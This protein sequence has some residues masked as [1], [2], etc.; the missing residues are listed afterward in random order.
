M[1]FRPG[2]NLSSQ[3]AATPLY[4]KNSFVI[5]ILLAPAC[6]FY[7]ISAGINLANFAI[8]LGT[9]H[10]S[11]SEITQILAFD[12][13]GNVMMAPL[14]PFLIRYFGIKKFIILSIILR[15]VFLF[16]FG[17][18]WSYSGW[19]L[20]MFGFG[21]FGFSLYTTIFQ[22]INMIASNE[23]RGTY[24]SVASVLFG[25]GMS[26][27]PIINS[28]FNLESSY[29]FAISALIATL[30][31]IPVYFLP[32]SIDYPYS[33]H[34]INITKLLKFS[35]IS[36]MCA[37][38]GEFTFYSMHEFL[39][40]YTIESDKG[41]SEAFMLISYFSLSGLMLGIP[42]GMIIDR[43]ERIKIIM[44]LV[45]GISAL[46]QLLPFAMHDTFFAFLIFS[47]LSACMNGVIICGLVIIGDKFRGHEFVAAH[48]TIQAIG[49][50]GAYAGIKCTGRTIELVG[51]DGLIYSVA[52][53]SLI[54]FAMLLI[55]RYLNQIRASRIY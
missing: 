5:L 11:T 20:S 54:C 53:V 22:L 39:P 3:N 13:I 4:N 55:E 29:D 2:T 31:I 24:L 14:M 50:V 42:I 41:Q 34:A 35:H 33:L 45:L 36:I 52:S 47:P 37:I 8:Y 12:I 40:V 19:V 49:M 48:S 32:K 17:F 25:L 26:L 46:I 30:M 44:I 51:A 43:F 1:I 21:L 6:F 38:V 15:N 7:G 27:G 9:F 23:Y 10:L 18:A 16:L 28:F